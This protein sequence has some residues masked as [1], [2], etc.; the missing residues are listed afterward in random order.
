MSTK[1]TFSVPIFRLDDWLRKEHHATVEIVSEVDNNLAESYTLAQ[2]QVSELLE[3]MNC[4]IKLA[5]DLQKMGEEVREKEEQLRILDFKIKQSEREYDS[6]ET[7]FT[8]LGIGVRFSHD[9]QDFKA[10]LLS[11]V[12]YDD[13][14][15]D[16]DD[17]DNPLR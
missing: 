17:D 11:E 3:Q 8:R 4:E 5:R 6:L 13:Y 2:N 1:I 9:H 16:D 12:Q 14:D 15:D 10:Y 7:F